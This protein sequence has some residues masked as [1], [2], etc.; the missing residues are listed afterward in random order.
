MKT[1]TLNLKFD[2]KALSDREFEGYGSVFHNV[3]LVG[4]IMAP[5]SFRKSLARHRT[6]GTM[7]LMF[8]MH[9]PDQVAGAWQSM[10]E[11][12][13][14]LKVKG[15]LADTPLG[16]EMRT[17][18]GMKAL[19]GLSIGFYV[20]DREW[21]DDEEHGA[22]RV[23]KEVELVEVSLV[24]LAAN[25]L[26]EVTASK[27]RLSAA[28]EYVPTAREFEAVLRKSGYSRSVAE[29]IALKVFGADDLRGSLTRHHQGEPD[30]SETAAKANR[31]LSA[32]GSVA[33]AV[34][35]EQEK[36]LPFWRR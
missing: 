31:F 9:Q 36:P 3:D 19:R 5:G 7:P 34:V 17:L 2:I 1:Q 26:A 6:N 33:E 23:I 27:A 12:E 21:E 35:V 29:R 32:L 16:N 22:V 14:G 24:S 15:V 11:D 10:T 8:W 30:L 25:P 20:R 4:D 28:G 18:L 13:H